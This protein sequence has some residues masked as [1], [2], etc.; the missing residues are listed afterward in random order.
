MHNTSAVIDHYRVIYDFQP[1]ISHSETNTSA[2]ECS[3]FG[4]DASVILGTVT[5]QVY[6]RMITKTCNLGLK[7]SLLC[8]GAHVSQN[9]QLRRASKGGRATYTSQA[10]DSGENGTRLPSPLLRNPSV[11]V[12]VFLNGTLHA[13][14]L[15]T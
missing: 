13:R 6:F 3:M 7:H 14:F 12:L 15:P 8:H 1:R 11:V 2:V 10:R 4:N 5:A 9:F